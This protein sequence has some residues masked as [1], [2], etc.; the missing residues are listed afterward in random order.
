MTNE[1]E[2]A[3]VIELGKA[4]DIVLGE[5]RDEQVL[6]GLTFEFGTRFIPATED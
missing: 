6:D 2:V 4:E 5:K 3:A 1:Y